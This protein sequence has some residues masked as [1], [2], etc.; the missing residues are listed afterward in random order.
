M[1]KATKLSKLV[2]MDDSIKIAG[3]AQ[4]SDTDSIPAGPPDIPV[5]TKE[6]LWD[7][8]IKSGEALTSVKQ[9]ELY[10]LLLGFADV[11]TS[12]DDGLR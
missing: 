11:F 3:I 12:I 2:P 7:L 10:N 6:Q 9:L 5:Y 8:V 4:G 1:Y